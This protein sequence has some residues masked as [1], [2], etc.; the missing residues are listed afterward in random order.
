M[1]TTTR[2][3]DREFVTTTM[4]MQMCHPNMNRPTLM[5]CE[6]YKTEK[7]YEV[8]T[9]A[10]RTCERISCVPTVYLTN[11]QWKER[12]YDAYDDQEKFF[13][14]MNLIGCEFDN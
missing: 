4:G 13:W 1:N 12:D 6:V 2:P 14:F 9:M 8:H 5:S 7:G 10:S 11:D 3:Q